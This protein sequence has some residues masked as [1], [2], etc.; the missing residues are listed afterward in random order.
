MPHGQHQRQGAKAKRDREQA[1]A[2]KKR[3]RQLGRELHRKEK[4]LAE[5]Q[6]CW[7]LR[8]KKLQ[9]LLGDDKRGELT[10]LPVRQKTM[11]SGSMKPLQTVHERKPACDE[12]GLLACVPSSAGP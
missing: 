4:A 9:C 3:I 1:K 6:H 2:D 8:K 7:Y 5:Q 11:S 10:S 12:L